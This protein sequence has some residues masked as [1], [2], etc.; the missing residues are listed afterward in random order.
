MMKKL[1]FVSILLLSLMTL[2]TFSCVD[3]NNA[4]TEPDYDSKPP[5]QIISVE[6]AVSMYNAQNEI[7]T[8]VINPALQKTYNDAHFEDTVFSW[9]SLDEM[10]QY[11]NYIDAIQEENPTEKVSRY[12]GVFW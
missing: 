2:M 5:Q 12:S 3:D 10:R 9:F 11:I 6:Q 8:K 7:K 1:Y 4:P